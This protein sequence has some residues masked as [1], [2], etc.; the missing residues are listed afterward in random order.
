MKQIQL[1]EIQKA[2][3]FECKMQEPIAYNIFTTI[4]C[5]KV[6]AKLLEEAFRCVIYEQEALR[7]C[8]KEE[9]ELMMEIK[10]KVNFKLGICTCK[11]EKELS[12]RVKAEVNRP[13]E[14]S[15]APLIR[16]VLIRM[17]EK[18]I[19]FICV[20]HIICDG[21]SMN[22]LVNKVMYFYNQLVNGKE[23][24]LNQDIGYAKFMEEENIKLKDGYYNLQKEYWK[25]QLEQTE[26]LTFPVDHAFTEKGD[27]IGKEVK[28]ELD[29]SVFNKIKKVAQELETSPYVVF[30]S[31]FATIMSKYSGKD[32]VIVASPFNYRTSFDLEET[33]G[34]FIYTL[35]L[36]I[37]INKA[38]SFTEIVR[39]TTQVVR[40]AYKNVGYPNNLIARDC[41]MNVSVG[42]PSLFDISFVY[43][44]Y[45][46]DKDNIKKIYDTD[47]ITFPG[48][49]MV[50]V[51]K[52]R[53]KVSLKIQYKSEIYVKES[54][55]YV[56]KR[57]M[58]VLQ[59]IVEN[60]EIIINQLDLFVPGE[61]EKI[62]K[63]FNDTTFFEY[64]PQHIV[65]LFEE[66][67]AKYSNE[68]AIFYKDEKFSYREVNSRA[69]QLAHKLYAIKKSKNEAIGIQLERTPEL[70]ISIL[71]VLKAGCAYVPIDK[72]YPQERKKFIV[73]DA[74]I[75]T[76]ITQKS[77]GDLEIPKV[78]MIYVDEVGLFSGPSENLQYERVCDDLAYIEYTSG[79]TGIPKGV[80]IEHVSITNTV[81]DLERRFPLEHQDVY[82]LKTPYTFDIFGTEFYG[83]IVG[84]GSLLV[85]E[86]DGEKNPDL[87][88]NAIETY[89]VTHINFV[90]SMFSI[91]LDAIQDKTSSEKIKSLRYFFVG[92]EAIKPELI[93]RFLKLEAPIKLENVYGPT[94]ATMWATHQSLTSCTESINVPI[95]KPLNEYR[96]YVVDEANKLQ[97]IGVPGELCISG[98][99]L[100]RGYLNREELS[101]EKFILN[102]FYDQEGDAKWFKKMYKTGDL[103]RWLP[104]GTLEFMGRMDFQVKVLGVRI[105][106]GEIENVM[107]R[108]EKITQAVAVIVGSEKSTSSI[109][110]YYISESP[111]YEEELRAFLTNQLPVYMIPTF[112]VYLQKL[113]LSSN[114]KVDRKVLMANTDYL[115]RENVDVV[116][117]TTDVEM[118]LA[119]IWK[120]VLGVDQ[121]GVTDD[122]FHLGGHSI[123][124]MQVHSKLLEVFHKEIGITQ[125]LRLRTIRQIAQCIEKDNEKEV[126]NRHK[127]FKKEK[128]QNSIKIAIVGMAVNVPCSESPKAFWENLVLGNECIHFYSEEELRDLGIDETS[129]NSENF[130]KAKGRIEELDY[131]D[132]VFFDSSPK[133][134]KMTSPQL[135]V[136]YKGI[137]QALEDAGCVPDIIEDKV[138]VFIGGSDDFAWYQQSL[139]K[140]ANYS[141]IYQSYT[142]STNHFLATRL[143]Y[144]FNLTG[145]GVSMLT[146]CSTSLVTTHLACQSLILG[147]C[148]IAI[149]GGVTVELPNEGGYMYEEGMMFSPD[150]HCR[151]FDNQAQGT[152]F[153][154]GMGLVVL[155]PLE[156]AI[157]EGD[158]I[159]ATIIGSAINNDGNKKMS[160][161]APS[162]DGQV[163]VIRQAYANAEVDPETIGYVEAHGTG[164]I[165][166][167][168]IEVS[169]LTRAFATDKTQY[170]VLGSVKGNVGHTDTAAGIVGVIKT[171][172]ALENKYLPATVNYNV[173]NHKINFNSTPFTILSKGKEWNRLA[174]DMP[175]RAG[176]NSFGVGGTNV[177]MVMEEAPSKRLSS[178]ERPYNLLIFSAKTE[179]ALN[180]IVEKIMKHIEVNK[181]INLSDVS[182]M[183]Q[184]GRKA[185]NYRKA[186]VIDEYFRE[187]FEEVLKD[188]LSA[189][190]VQVQ[191]QDRPVYF[192]FS[193]QGSQYQG[194]SKMLYKGADLYPIGSLYKDYVDEVFGLLNE[195]ERK[196]FYEIIFGEDNTSLINQ[197]KYSQFALFV[198]EYALAKTL[199]KL[200]I[201]PKALVGHSIGEIVAATIA[202]V[203]SLKDGVEIVRMRGELMQAQQPGVMLA[204]MSDVETIRPLLVENVWISLSNTTG[205]CVVGGTDEAIGIFETCLKSKDIESTRIKTSHAFHTP[206]MKEAA[207]VFKEYLCSIQMNSPSYTIISNLTGRYVEEDELTNPEYWAKHI[208]QTVRFEEDLD[209]MMKEK[210]CVGIEIGVGRTLTSFAIA[211]KNRKPSHTFINILPHI[212]EE[213]GMGYVYDKLGKLWT[214]GVQ[215]NWN[216]LEGKTIRNKISLPTYVFDKE[217]YPIKL[218]DTMKAKVSTQ[219]NSVE[220]TWASSNN[221]LSLKDIEGVDGGSTI[222]EV[223]INAYK[224]IFGFE[225]VDSQAD[226][227]DMGGDSLT[228]A[229]LSA[230]LK[231]IL[232][233]KVTV[234]NIFNEIT[235][236][237]LANF[238]SANNTQFKEET[239]IR[240]IHG[241]AYYPLSSS[242]KRMYT[243][244]LL[245]KESVTYN[246]SSAT[247]IEGPLD[248]KRMEKAIR[249][250]IDRHES[251]RT[252]FE[253]KDG[254]IVQVINEIKSL[255][256]EYSEAICDTNQDFD[257]ILQRFIKPFDLAEAP[258]FRV[259][260]VKIA[261]DKQI[262]LFDIHHI[263]A[264][265]TGVE[266]IS[267][268]FNALYFGELEPL[269]IQ[270]KDYA[271]WQLK[272]MASD[273]MKQKKTYWLDVLGGSLPT[274]DLPT[275]FERPRISS[276]AGK[277]MQF[278]IEPQFFGKIK[279]LS[280][281]NGATPFMTMLSAW[282]IL[283]ASY[284]NQEELIVGTPVSGRSIDE[285]RDTVGMF[286]NMLPIRS[287]P[288]RE[289][290]FNEYLKEVREI[291][292]EALQN[293]EYQF[294]SLVG[295]LAIKRELNHNPIFDVSFDY[296]N[297]EI[298]DLEI[299]DLK[300][301]SYPMPINSVSVDLLLT[302]NEDSG[303]Y[304]E[305]FIDYST[306]L[307]NEETIKKMMQHYK[308]I[309]DEV[310]VNETCKIGEINFLTVEEK[311]VIDSQFEKNKLQ[312][313]SHI[314]IHEMFERN[315]ERMPD[316][317][318]LINA[319]NTAFT[320]AQLNARANSLAYQLIENGVTR[321][322]PVGIMCERN[323]KMI[324]A[325]LAILKA[326]G[327]YVP[328]DTK[329]PKDRI[330]YILS[331][332][333]A[334]VIICAKKYMDNLTYTG[335]KINCDEDYVGE[336][337][338]ENPP[339]RSDRES[340]AYIIFTS[341]STGTPKGVLVKQEGV[342]NL[343]YDHIERHIFEKEEERIACIAT[344][345]FDIFVFETLL[346]L[347]TGHSLYV[348]NEVEQLDISLL[349]SKLL[350]HQVTHIQAPVSR[351]RV[352]TEN[353]EF[354]SVLPHLKVIV[355]GGEYYPKSFMRY[356]QEQTNAKLYNMY[357]PTETT[358]TATIKDLTHAD[359]VN[360]GNAIANTQVFIVNDQN[361]INPLGI[362]GEICI[363]GKGL[364]RGYLNNE[365]ETQQKFVTLPERPEVQVYKT[366]DNGRMLASG[367]VEILGRMDSQIKVHGYRIELSE[368]EKVALKNEQ[369]SYAVA[370]VFE[371]NTNPQ[372]ALFYCTNEKTSKVTDLQVKELLQKELPAY[373]I[374]TTIC[375]LEQMPILANGKVDRRALILDKAQNVVETKVMQD[376]LTYIE[377]AIVDIWK[378]VLGI[379]TLSVHD[380]FFDKGGNSFALMSVNNRINELVG[381]SVPLMQLF[382]NPTIY[383]FIKSLKIAESSPLFMCEFDEDEGKKD[384]NI[385]VIGMYCELPGAAGVE[386]LWENIVNGKESIVQFSKEELRANGISEE[387]I[388]HPNY[389]NAKGYL[390]G[391]E[392]FDS[393][394]FGYSRKEASI[395]DPQIRLLHM[396]VWHALEDA[397]YNSYDFGGKIGLFAGSGANILWMSKFLNKQNNS[398]SAFEAMTLN[399]KDF[400][401]TKVSYK[402]NL[403]GPSINIQTACST[404]LVAIHEAVKSLQ[405]G[406]TD[407][408]V[409]GGVS[410]SYPRKE[411]YLWH[412]G[413]IYSQDGHCRPFSQDSSG[414]VSG[415]GCGIVVLKKLSSAL[416]DKDHIY[417]VVKG[418]AMNN[419]GFDKIGYTAPSILGQKEVIQKA[420]KKAKVKPEEIQY[421][422]AHGTGTIL[423]DP[424]EVEA[425]RQAWGT[426]KKQY[427]AI[428]SLKA[429][430]GHLDA[431]SG[432]AGFIKT[433]L[434]LNKKV[435]P[436]VINYKGANPKVDI[437]NSPFYINE[438]CEN[439]MEDMKYA[440]VSSFGIGGTNVHVILEEA[441]PEKEEKVE[442]KINLLVFSAKS[443]SALV[444]TTFNVLEYI[445]K[446][447]E[448]QLDNAA[449]TLQVG[450]GQFEYRKAFVVKNGIIESD[451]DYEQFVEHKGNKIIESL[452][453]TVLVLAQSDN[454]YKK[455]G[456][457]LYR[458]IGK[459]HVDEILSCLSYQE[460]K[461]CRAIILENASASQKEQ[462]IMTFITNYVVTM[463]LKEMGIEINIVIGKGLDKIKE[464]AS[465]TSKLSAREE[466]TFK[467]DSEV[468]TVIDL[469]GYNTE[470]FIG[471][472]T[473][474]I[475]T[476][477]LY[478]MIG[479]L[480]CRGHKVD[481][482]KLNDNRALKR[483]SLP[484][485]VFEKSQF[486]CDMTLSNDGVNVDEEKPNQVAKVYESEEV[487]REAL[488]NI[489]KEVLGI[490]GVS[491]KDDFF[492]LGGDS[493][494]SVL[495][496]SIM[497]KKLGVQMPMEEIFRHSRFD[498]MSSWLYAHRKEQSFEHIPKIDKQPYYETSCAQKRMYT[499]NEIL[500]DT[501]AYN[502][503]SVYKVEGKLDELKLKDAFDTL[504]KRHASFRTSFELKDGDIVQYV[505]DEVTSVVE[506]VRVERDVL[507]EEIRKAIR[508]FDLSVAPLIRVKLLRISE[509]EHI[510]IVDMHHIISDQ[511]SINRLLSELAMLY[512]GKTL[513]PIPITYVDFAAWQNQLL[514]NGQIENQLAYWKDELSGEVAK[515]ELY[516]DYM[517]SMNSSRHGKRLVFEIDKEKKDFINQWTKDKHLTTY[518]L[519][520]AA[521]NLLLW[522]YTDQEDLTI[523]TV[524]EGRRHLEVQPMVGMFV[525][526]LPIRTQIDTT[527]T[528]DKYLEYIKEKI[529][530]AFENQ[531]CQ[532]E[533]ILEAL[534]GIVA[535]DN[536]PLFDIILN[537]VREESGELQLGDLKF[538]PWEADGVDVK[539]DLSLTVVEKQDG[540]SIEIEYTDT[541]FKESTIRLMGE[542]FVNLVSHL[543]NN[544]KEPLT[545]ISLLS[546]EDQAYISDVLNVTQ[547]GISNEQNV[548]NMFE[549]Y[550]K[551]Q[552]WH[553]ALI[554]KECIYSYKELNAKVN[555]LSYVLHEHQV[556]YGDHVAILIERGPNQI[557]SMLAILK[558]GAVYVPIDCEYPSDRI[559][560]I[561]QDSKSKLVITSYQSAEIVLDGYNLIN[562]DEVMTYQNEIV[563]ESVTFEHT[564]IT[565]SAEDEAYI[566][567]TSGSTGTPKGTV[568]CHKGIIRTCINTNYLSV[569][570]KDTMAQMTNYT[571]DASVWEVF[572]AFLNGARLLMISK[573]ELLEMQQLKESFSKYRVTKAIFITAIFNMVVDYDVTLLRSIDTIYVGGEAMSI[574]HTRRALGCVGEGRIINLYGPTEATVC[575]SYYSVNNIDEMCKSIPIGRPISNATLYV[576]DKFG[577]IM[578][579]K[580]PGELCIGGCGLAKGYLNQEELT[581][582]KF[583][584]LA[585]YNNERVY[586]TGDKVI[587][588]EDGTIEFIGRMDFQIKLRG[589]RVELEE[590]EKKIHLIEAIK[591]VVVVAKED[592]AGS[593]YIAAYYTA[594]KLNGKLITVEELHE[595]L[596]NQLPEYM[597]PSRMMRM[598][599][600]PITLN[601]KIDRKALP[602]IQNRSM[603]KQYMQPISELERRI[604]SS[605]QAVLGNNEIS[606]EDNFFLV[607]GQ[608]IKA[609]A[610]AQKLRE[611]GMEIR[612]N[613]ILNYPTVKELA[614]LGSNIEIKAVEEGNQEKIVINDYQIHSLTSYICKASE[615]LGKMM[616][617]ESIK[618]TFA[619]SPIQMAHRNMKQRCSGF[620]MCVEEPE[621]SIRETIVDIISKQQMLHSVW[622][623]E[624]GYTWH[625]LNIDVLSEVLGQYI[626]VVD[627]TSYE[628]NIQNQIIRDVYEQLFSQTYCE[629]EIP[630]KVCCLKVKSKK[631]QLIWCFDH[632]CF[633]GMSAEIIR[634]QFREAT[635]KEGQDDIEGKQVNYAMYVKTLK[636]GPVGISSEEIEE[637]FK[638]REWQQM[639]ELLMQC[640]DRCSKG[641]QPK[642]I[643]VDIPL[644]ERIKTNIWEYACHI[645]Q[646][647]LKEYTGMTCIPMAVVDY[648]RRYGENK[649][650]D[651]VGEFLDIVPMMLEDENM[652]IEVSRRL[653]YCCTH[654]INFLALIYD[655]YIN[656]CY[657]ELSSCLETSY[658]SSSECLRMFLYN[659]QGYIT[660]EE[661]Q[662]FNTN[663]SNENEELLA[664][665]SVNVSFDE[666]NLYIH[667]NCVDG[668]DDE[669]IMSIAARYGE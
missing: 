35:P 469:D 645:V 641:G 526:T 414:T 122:F 356:L 188:T 604:L 291:T 488:R 250:L 416:K 58:D 545:Q 121:V 603:A 455:I 199:M 589:F 359:E 420:L 156:K 652:E 424:I 529:M 170:C 588:Q 364:S 491:S 541:L 587:M 218:E 499:V 482:F 205:K 438:Q 300:F 132:S 477:E 346:P 504:V 270:Y 411:G 241:Q 489:W 43:D 182:W 304:L 313:D 397:G 1:G 224:E 343:I 597:M 118:K 531:D 636:E 206:M 305:C 288:T 382:E 29:V 185:F 135:R 610:F 256:I 639:N 443:E 210:G 287:F 319:D 97:P 60:K 19:C 615:T 41:G 93:E 547:V 324:I 80:M 334:P 426:S 211:H 105:E 117:P 72:Q 151:P 596:K 539:Y 533:M 339:R 27:G 31:V 86:E 262:L 293:Q 23:V 413:M 567:Y 335:I 321:D 169:S 354:L 490:D 303:E 251:L 69:N 323:E 525:N 282:N 195:E 548:V 179:M 320:Y 110:V 522:K 229:S 448:I 189:P 269:T 15:K 562:I 150:G 149:A 113:P 11:N 42:A 367:E 83:W 431:A 296:H 272:H 585:A 5:N 495:I 257:G 505:L 591:D 626:C 470:A 79:S 381:Y 429:N 635:S 200:G 165:L 468:D 264:D 341:G 127:L 329:F 633:D 231:K 164:T 9:N 37:C 207:Q 599:Q 558:C 461:A 325:M 573:E 301:T 62:L 243:F 98:V 362:A 619:L 142:L 375:H 176:I 44:D 586:K 538:T 297:M 340:L 398:V 617:M 462:E 314:L 3:Y 126:I 540:L 471:F 656:E 598:E 255:P 276:F 422:E 278:N 452:G 524:V 47:E 203:W 628:T 417:A 294:D 405:C 435:I 475:D 285:V 2:I 49:M 50:I 376:S 385:A 82:M 509:E 28:S 18:D 238:I 73:D 352:M 446:H 432:V 643:C 664:Y 360:I 363:A 634:R 236:K 7:S 574:D 88:I 600:L 107:V 377:K 460:R 418:S 415:N 388:N 616:S 557:I 366:G 248:V 161:T 513:E 330:G 351:L 260:L 152:V 245:D 45:D 186:I 20:H 516:T 261:S 487:M 51:E 244:Y 515:L 648:G 302:C 168:P 32:N 56:C 129:L 518:M 659:F 380:N 542:R 192:M 612:V 666:S 658:Q 281:N 519:M 108:H 181:N 101:K 453:N 663:V 532:F 528:V 653:A 502:L 357:G 237:R 10:D 311:S 402:M 442:C 514:K 568:L 484:G 527:I 503:A 258:L 120:K 336:E 100:A 167:D 201:I 632:M 180:N 480:W 419:D 646:E 403:K 228:A 464:L 665:L 172:L 582:D 396:C 171:A 606:V 81:L 349:A 75:S 536:N 467:L 34:C 315:V 63:E 534:E 275:D 36:K 654:H 425:L 38:E 271:I 392:Y 520:V 361:K 183:L 148:D 143:S 124:V 216:K 439:R 401:T 114:G 316:K 39:Q 433:V 511:T 544:E 263:I 111:I 331:E 550:V 560:F 476:E 215:V 384:D 622:R 106:L 445:R 90:P 337:E 13:F 64:N 46:V 421:V 463:L 556:G 644:D 175:L 399:D 99:G 290:T 137:W 306:A 342:I 14:L 259:E 594:K 219:E 444:N 85:V 459:Q 55:E 57:F 430:I 374:P 565:L 213:Q 447:K 155:K 345:S 508:S 33:I 348:A 194:M 61:E 517:K 406:E 134:V 112:F 580:I 549:T 95:G 350:T 370:K 125:L 232:G 128:R 198:V 144:K 159:Y 595:T 208:Q 602:V 434:V 638:L 17:S 277:R 483:I 669:K 436:P 551:E 400:L 308:N 611:L 624:E 6:N 566:I 650:Y 344:P 570:T 371:S 280:R 620:T 223:I 279:E 427:C 230:L 65:H 220:D 637:T 393:N 12:E 283:L 89:K 474:V 67:V 332:T 235:P 26:P 310:I 91:F 196:V 166:G 212:K 225:E 660:T 583:I 78:G 609:I 572:G 227:F 623:N 497:H 157:E 116:E 661:Q 328:I 389:V 146:G 640:L 87:I 103:A 119:D 40:S 94:E 458:G 409:A 267:R 154:N 410:I 365:N 193:G 530:G 130:V 369:V 486:D 481:W 555:H 284:A 437:E 605:M 441:P 390:D 163:E 162:E 174:E 77:L 493:L 217:Y 412:E 456:L 614:R 21:L 454:G 601:G 500:G 102:P 485:Y 569:T 378:E 579:P 178:P 52:I 333:K 647:M 312:I 109:C 358:V 662:M 372:I 307:F 391:V 326:G 145:P 242:Q 327:A 593:L 273:E 466:L 408:A 187:R 581:K 523:G 627:I 160:Y 133:E 584:N 592:D 546:S 510:L 512:E 472:H 655:K 383:R 501:L 535:G 71:A 92:G 494:T 76:V 268:D 74:N 625:E 577:N 221:V 353:E 54:I 138:G 347:C 16:S 407:M 131:F 274:L 404:S 209:V 496:A 252:S 618:T 607:G 642:A 575:A 651:C 153:S 631:F 8:I 53:N 478:T 479:A 629:G 147:E 214:A 394:F 66:K 465:I 70:V 576:V 521:L 253:M 608:S 428:G 449:W 386:S 191:K 4:E 48:S 571:F 590:I 387:M 246:L 30:L 140:N 563:S 190:S 22:I 564:P 266:I 492:E 141:D 630:W 204:V 379:D 202:G 498:E 657:D 173:P 247:L 559:E 233:I 239:T 289:K 184:M 473:K 177:H 457:N 24:D 115:R 123:G 355:G 451:K 338:L 373:M 395:M 649:F 59:K 317:I 104:D 299:K 554:W 561:L 292:L 537:Y 667:F 552:P 295:D 240:P 613:D 68:T 506:I 368:I 222:E 249:K 139:Y 440:A 553:D 25:Q 84:K 507:E 136:L 318:A 621:Q 254:E 668:F 423:G 450:R 226:F 234:Q 96:C 197:T 158:H 286:V 298:Y 578:P 322:C 543:I 265:G 309:L